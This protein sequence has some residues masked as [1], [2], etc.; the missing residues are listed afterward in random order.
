MCWQYRS[1]KRLNDLFTK[2]KT[3]SMGPKIEVLIS[4]PMISTEDRMFTWSDWYKIHLL[5]GLYYGELC[6]ITSFWK[7]VLFISSFA[8]AN[9]KAGAE[10]LPNSHVNSLQSDYRLFVII[11][12]G[13]FMINDALEQFQARTVPATQTCACDHRVTCQRYKRSSH[14]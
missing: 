2:G 11:C 10:Y 7:Y 1:K 4:S 6:V 9:R 13:I 14:C 8:V 3:S 5:C 12:L